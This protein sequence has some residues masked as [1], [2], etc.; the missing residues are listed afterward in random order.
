MVD[1]PDSGTP[2]SNFVFPLISDDFE[3]GTG[4][5]LLNSGDAPAVVQMELWGSSGT[6]D[7]SAS[8]VL[9]PHTQRAELQPRV[10]RPLNERVTRRRASLEEKP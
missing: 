2:L 8:V 7:S 1:Y 9:A 3:Y 6:L 4:I 5:A 10:G